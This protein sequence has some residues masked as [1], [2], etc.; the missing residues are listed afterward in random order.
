MENVMADPSVE[1]ALQQQMTTLTPR[2]PDNFGGMMEVEI[3]T[4][5]TDSA[6]FSGKEV[7]D[8]LRVLL[9]QQQAREQQWINAIAEAGLIVGELGYGRLKVY[10]HRPRPAK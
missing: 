6:Y 3:I 9:T 7:A 2:L 8:R 4:G 1:S 10:R 5:G